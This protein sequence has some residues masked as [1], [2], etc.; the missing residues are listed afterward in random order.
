MVGVPTPSDWAE[1]R[2]RKAASISISGARDMKISLVNEE[3]QENI[4]EPLRLSGDDPA[5]RLLD[6]FPSIAP[7]P[8]SPQFQF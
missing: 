5:D 4:V 1:M 6:R 7:S 3:F 2:R 8:P